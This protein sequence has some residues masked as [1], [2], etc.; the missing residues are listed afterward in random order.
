MTAEIT[1]IVE[2][3]SNCSSIISTS[4]P[5]TYAC[6]V[7]DDVTVRCDDCDQYCDD[8]MDSCG[9]DAIC[10][11]CKVECIAC[12]DEMPSC[13]EQHNY[14]ACDQHGDQHEDY[15]CK[16]CIVYCACSENRPYTHDLLISENCM[17]YCMDCREMY[18]SNCMIEHEHLDEYGLVIEAA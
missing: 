9:G 13:T 16:D 2:N 15:V 6:V 12:G 17:E 8:C 3:C 10:P 14:C 4:N 5:R 18:C 11:S 7:C 1:T